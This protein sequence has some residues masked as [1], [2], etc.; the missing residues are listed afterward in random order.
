MP[1]YADLEIGLL[2][3]DEQSYA[4]ETRFSAP[5]SDADKRLPGTHLVKFDFDRLQALLLDPQEYGTQLSRDLFS[6][7]P[8]VAEFSSA[9]STA[10]TNNSALRLRLVISSRTPELHNLLWETLISPLDQKP[11]GA[12]QNILFSR[13]LSS[14]DWRPVKPRKKEELK[15]LV[16]IA[17]PSGLDAYRLAPVDAAGELERARSSLDPIPVTPLTEA[18][19]PKML[20][21]L[22]EGSFDILYLVAHGVLYQ[23]RPAIFLCNEDGSVARTP[24]SQLSDRLKDLQQTPRLVVLASCQS[25]GT[26]QVSIEEN[27][28]ASGALSALGP[29]LAEAGIPAVL[30]MQGN[31]TMKTIEVFMPVFFRELQRD[32]QIDRAIAAARTAV[33][34]RPDYWMPALF[35]RLT[36]GRIWYVPGFRTKQSGVE[37]MPALLT[38]IK[39]RR[40]T[41]IIGPGLAEPLIGS[42]REIAQRWANKHHYPMLP[43]GRES[44]PQVT[45]YLSIFQSQIFPKMAL[46]EYLKEEIQRKYAGDLLPDLLD[47]WATLDE[48][49]DAAGA[50]YRKRNPNDPYTLLAQLPLPIYITTN[51]HNLLASALREAG[52]SP[53]VIICPWNNKVEQ[54][55]SLYRLKEDYRPD[56]SRP[57]IF[58][59]FG[60]LDEPDSVVLTEDDYFNFLI[61]V[62]K[63]WDLIPPIIGRALTDSAL[64]FLGFQ[65]D[66]WS[67]RILLR[68]F[69]SR[70]G[71]DR[72]KTYAHVA[73]QIEPEE[74]RFIEPERARSILE[75]YLAINASVSIFWGSADDFLQ[76]LW[77]ELNQ[78]KTQDSTL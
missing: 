32:G 1:T 55:Q 7:P 65:I 21:A 76:Q 30:A 22:Q 26:G 19:L 75:K 33:L 66:E 35:M 8:V 58:H 51:Q 78:G 23:G 15:A 67:F 4:I 42:H 56:R 54:I 29:R 24:G 64:L 48:V 53:E 43:Q 9:L 73:A 39:G 37:I 68:S 34:D 44:L 20:D 5:G 3:H 16:V 38:F 2:Y 45:Q 59:L 28:A 11:I 46:G 10:Q 36:S 61:G 31:I 62:T 25:S 41:P 52:K 77:Q 40:C 47:D 74:G 17:N 6:N 69:L 63:N 71:A 12:N 49:I 50:A 14:F 57:L 13:Y 27:N 18:T 72:L 70:D 60:R